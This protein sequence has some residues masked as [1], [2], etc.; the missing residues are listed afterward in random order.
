MYRTANFNQLISQMGQII[1]GNV[2]H[3]NHTNCPFNTSLKSSLHTSLPGRTGF[4]SV[5][6]FLMTEYI[7]KTLKQTPQA[8]SHQSVL[9]KKAHFVSESEKQVSI[10]MRVSPRQCKVC[11]CA[12][13]WAV[14]HSSKRSHFTQLLWHFRGCLVTLAFV[15]YPYIQM[16]TL[17]ADIYSWKAANLS[18]NVTSTCVYLKCKSFRESLYTLQVS[19]KQQHE[20]KPHTILGL[21]IRAAQIWQKS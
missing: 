20:K 2:C 1:R 18:L 15:Q 16:F 19:K 14:S 9:E 11:V 8:Q 21:Y 17:R 13:C 4:C 12:P 6:S 7:I 10:V 3:Q 5:L